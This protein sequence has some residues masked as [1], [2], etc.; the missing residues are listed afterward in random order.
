MVDIARPALFQPL[1]NAPQ[2]GG[3]TRHRLGATG[4]RQQHQPLFKCARWYG[5]P[6]RIG[7]A[8]RAL[9]G[10]QQ[11]TVGSELF[12]IGNSFRPVDLDGLVAEMAACCEYGRGVTGWPA[13]LG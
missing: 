11:W 3:K 6:M 7:V 2:A 8:D 5:E 1:G 13:A 9:H 4:N 12:L 10:G